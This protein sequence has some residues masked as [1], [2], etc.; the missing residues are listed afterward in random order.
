MVVA[1]A[2]GAAIV[3]YRHAYELVHTHGEDGVTA[4]IVPATVDGLIFAAGMVLLSAARRRVRPPALAYVG[5]SLGIVATLGANVAH[6]WDHGPIG[7]LVSAWPAVALIIAYELLMK[8]V[9]SAGSGPDEPST[10]PAA[11]TAPPCPHGVADTVEDAALNAFVHARDCVG[12]AMSQ[13]QVADRFGLDR[14]RV[15]ILVRAHDEPASADERTGASGTATQ[16]EPA[17]VAR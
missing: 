16:D 17:E 13:R 9:R 5:L 4:F 10:E 1:V 12:E 11:A 3:S 2:V 14:K 15:G 8:L 7:A 6:G